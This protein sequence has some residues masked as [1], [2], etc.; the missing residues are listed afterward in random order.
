MEYVSLVGR[1]VHIPY[2]ALLSVKA[3]EVVGFVRT[4]AG[5]NAIPTVII[6]FAW[7]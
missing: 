6:M 3:P 1:Q 4:G 7:A 5:Q 2:N